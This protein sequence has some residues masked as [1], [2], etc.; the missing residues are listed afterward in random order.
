MNIISPWLDIN[1]LPNCIEQLSHVQFDGQ[2]ILVKLPA[3]TFDHKTRTIHKYGDPHDMVAQYVVRFILVSD[4]A[5]QDYFNDNV[6]Y[7]IFMQPN[8]PVDTIY[9][10]INTEYG[11]MSKMPP[12]GKCFR[13]SRILNK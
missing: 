4:T 1:T 9:H 7:T 3:G 5:L 8:Y 12:D 10:P 13:V 2:L 11:P 6:G